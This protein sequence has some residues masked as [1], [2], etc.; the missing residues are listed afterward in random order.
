[1][2]DGVPDTAVEMVL[3]KDAGGRYR[4]FVYACPVCTPVLEAFRAYALRKEYQ[5]GRKGDAYR[6][7]AVAEAVRPAVARL[8]DGDIRARGAALQSLVERAV[9]RGMER[10]RLAGEERSRLQEALKIG[11]KRGT[12]SLR[13]GAS[14]G[15]AHDACPSCDGGV[16]REW[17]IPSGRK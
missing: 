4:N 16:G 17:E 9:S 1:G 3:Q 11:M 12:E 14:P 15:F 6:A 8:E 5:Y 7:D 10:R 13:S 2:E